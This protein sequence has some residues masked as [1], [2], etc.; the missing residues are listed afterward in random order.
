MDAIIS[1]FYL[2]LTEVAHIAELTINLI[3]CTDIALK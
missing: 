1:M 2:K 3:K